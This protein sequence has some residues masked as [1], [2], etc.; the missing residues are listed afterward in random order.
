LSNLTTISA[1][2]GNQTVMDFLN[3]L[4]ISRNRL[5]DALPKPFLQKRVIDQDRLEIPID[6][7]NYG[8][9]NPVYLGPAVEV[10]TDERRCLVLLKP[11]GIHSHPHS[12]SES[13]NLLSFMRQEERGDL[14]VNSANYDRGLLY[15]LDNE[16]SGLMIYINDEELLKKAR[17]LHSESDH[18]KGY[19]AIVEGN[20]QDEG[21]ISH[22]IRP[23]GPKGSKMVE[24][25][26]ELASS[27]LAQMEILERHYNVKADRSYVRLRLMT[28]HRHQLRVQLSI[29]GHPIIGDHLYGGSQADRMYLHCSE[30]RS[31]LL[32]EYL[33]PSS[34]KESILKEN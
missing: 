25:K 22:Y 18:Y 19:E 12:Y 4:G 8:M 27:P 1:I 10:V 13:N 5:K 24:D 2:R 23:F 16:T 20:I 14:S 32:G 28:G 9:I 34:F 21:V 6:L 15:R 7:L 29:L 11:S 31:P 17:S 33:K 3:S 26:K 30:F